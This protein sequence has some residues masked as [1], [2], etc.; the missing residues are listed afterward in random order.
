MP[1]RNNRRLYLFDIDGTLLST[2]GAA[3]HA[4]GLAFERVFGVADGISQRHFY[5]TQQGAATWRS[6]KT[7]S[8][9]QASQ[10]LT[11]QVM[12]AG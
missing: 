2:G 11:S 5:S 4:M 7:H 12:R 8:L 6:C 10:T 9:T 1:R 3:S